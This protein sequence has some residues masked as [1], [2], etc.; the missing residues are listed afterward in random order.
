MADLENLIDL[1]ML[2]D[3]GELTVVPVVRDVRA[4]TE[5]ETELRQ[6]LSE[7]AN[8]AANAYSR[9]N[10]AAIQAN[11]AYNAASALNGRLY[12]ASAWPAVGYNASAVEGCVAVGCFAR[13]LDRMCTAVGNGACVSSELSIAV[14]HSAYSNGPHSMAVGANSAATANFAVAAG[15]SALATGTSAVALGGEALSGSYSVSVGGAAMARKNDSVA[16]GYAANAA[17][18][19]STALGQ[20]SFTE[21]ESTAVGCNAHTNHLKCVALGSMSNAG[22][23]YSVALGAVS[24]TY[25]DGAT[26]V[27]YAASASGYN[28]TALGHSASATASNSIQLGNASSLS[29]ITARV[30][31]TTT[32]DERDKADISEIGDGAVEFLKKVKAIRYVFNHRELYIDEGSLSEADRAKRLKYGLCPY[33]KKAHAA[34]TRKGKRIRAGVSAQ[35]TLEAL[36]EV[37]GDASYANLVNDSLFDFKPE[38]IPE[39]VESQLTA[40]YEGFVP[41]LVKAVQ[42]LAGRLERLEGREGAWGNF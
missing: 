39:G 22:G 1:D 3:F 27:G 36:K 24:H 10:A 37:Y 9:A 40:N 21:E 14:G 4:L 30:G 32:S 13:A 17:G 23:N 26:A 41:F 5:K 38:E 28:S 18:N 8:A 16:L 33:D 31:I 2:K 25:L 19:K 7:A 11:S 12:G 20:N 34:G 29:S 35:N 6:N 15:F 42:E